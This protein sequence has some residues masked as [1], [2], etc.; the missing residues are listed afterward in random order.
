MGSPYNRRFRPNAALLTAIL[1]VTC[2]AFSGA[3]ASETFIGGCVGVTDGDTI[4]VMRDGR[5]V[6]VRLEA[7]DCPEQGQDFSAA[8]KKYTS[9][10]VRV[11]C[12]FARET[13]GSC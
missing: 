6:K 7:I 2:A 9:A 11:R 10:L 8:A 12:P 13:S 4:S 5:A 3:D 1:L